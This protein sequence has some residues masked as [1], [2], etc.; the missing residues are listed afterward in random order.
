[1]RRDLAAAFRLSTTLPVRTHRAPDRS[2][3]PSYSGVGKGNAQA[4]KK[5]IKVHGDVYPSLQAAMREMRVS[6]DTL[7]RWIANGTA[8][9]V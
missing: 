4:A 1:M 8:E 5:S 2:P 7:K 6:F 9:Y 3:R